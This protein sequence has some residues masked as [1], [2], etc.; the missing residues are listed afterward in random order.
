MTDQSK[1]TMRIDLKQV[2]S[3]V[4]VNVKFDLTPAQLAEMGA[5][6]RRDLLASIGTANGA[7]A[8]NCLMF[9]WAMAG[10]ER[11][12]S[13]VIDV[14]WRGFDCHSA[15]IEGAYPR[16]KIKWPSKLKGLASAAGRL[17]GDGRRV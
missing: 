2:E 11:G 17:L 3:G 13:C 5:E 14:D 15:R 9:V 10:D 16:T 8:I 1:Q 7:K 4:A 6:M 12:K